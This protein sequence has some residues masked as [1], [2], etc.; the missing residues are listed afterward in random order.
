MRHVVT[1]RLRDLNVK[2]ALELD[3]NKF[4]DNV[5]IEVAKRELELDGIEADYQIINLLTH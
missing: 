1:R 2:Y 4:F 3:Y 5:T